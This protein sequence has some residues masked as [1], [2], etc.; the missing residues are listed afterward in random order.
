[1]VLSRFASAA[2]NDTGIVPW[3]QALPVGEVN[4]AVGAVLSTA[5]FRVIVATLPAVS[6]TVTAIVA[7]PSK[8]PG[9]SQ[10]A[11]HRPVVGSRVIVPEA[12]PAVNDT[13]ATP[14]AS[15]AAACTVMG[16]WTYAFAAGARIDPAGLVESTM[17]FTRMGIWGRSLPAPPTP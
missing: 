6:V 8:V 12:A 3:T 13:E 7:A 17:R 10:F 9:V 1:V 5:T 2:E 11:V 14:F 4:D 15:N 16:P